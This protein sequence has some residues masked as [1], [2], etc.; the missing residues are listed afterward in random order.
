MKHIKR[1]NESN[2]PHEITDYI[3]EWIEDEKFTYEPTGSKIRL[4]YSGESKSQSA[5]FNKYET[6]LKRLEPSYDVSQKSIRIEESQGHQAIEII[7]QLDRVD[8][9]KFEF[10]FLDKVF[11]GDITSCQL[12]RNIH[13]GIISIRINLSNV[14]FRTGNKTA[15]LR[16]YTTFTGPFTNKNCSREIVI[17]PTDMNYPQFSI[18]TKNVEKILNIIKSR[19]IEFIDTQQLEQC[20]LLLNDI[21]TVDLADL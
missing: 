17:N 16:F 3:L 12:R 15:Q 8:D 6:L 9:F 20:L 18:D 13:W 4:F 21:D 11:S 14:S 2:N 5:I 1:F 7:I 10:R 19:N